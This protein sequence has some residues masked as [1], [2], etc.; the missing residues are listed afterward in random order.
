VTSLQY[1]VGTFCSAMGVL[2]LVAPHQFN[3]PA[4]AWLQGQLI[5]WG[6][7]FLAAGVGLLIVV[8]MLPRFVL[9]VPVHL[10]A[11]GLLLGLAAGFVRT[12][13]WSGTAP[14]LVLGLGTAAAPLLG[15]LVVQRSWLRGE[16]FPLFL[17]FGAL[18]S[19]LILLALPGNFGASRYDLARPV[20][21]WFG[22]AFCASAIL[23]C[24]G[25]TSR[26]VPPWLGRL[27]PVL[28]GGVFVVFGAVTA[29]PS[30][31]WTSGIFYG[32][33]GAA[34]IVLSMLPA[35]LRRFDPHALP[36]RL[37]LVVAAAVVVPLVVRVG[38][39]QQPGVPG[40]LR[41]V[42]TPAGCSQRARPECG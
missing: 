30:H 10:W 32:E 3:A 19:G 36:T 24:A 35:R 20:L 8:S 4:F 17:G 42:G 23:V 21:G 11:G 27:A 16:A 14:Y 25:Q 38:V 2:M 5:W 29:V 13:V 9:V 15:H 1:A 6:V 37:A 31:D 41:A 33:F 34:L 18:L 26:L 7:G 40:R 28:L 39:C 12:G 22:L